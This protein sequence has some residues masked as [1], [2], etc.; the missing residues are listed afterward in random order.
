MKQRR[1]RNNRDKAFWGAVIP[2]AI[3]LAGSI[4]GTYSSHEA[5]KQAMAEQKREAIRQ[6]TLA[7][8]NADA[9]TLN[10]YYSTLHQN[11]YDTELEYKFGGSRRIGRVA[12]I[13]DGGYSIPLGRGLSLLQG[14]SHRTRNASGHTGIGIRTGNKR[15]EG[16]GGEIVQQVPGALRVFSDKLPVAGNNT[17]A[18]L[19]LSGENPDV[20][21]NAQET[22]KNYFGL[23]N[24][25]STNNSRKY[26]ARRRRLRNGGSSLPV[27]RNAS[28]R[29]KALNGA[30]Y[31]TPDYIGLGTNILGSVLSGVYANRKYRDL[32][33]DINYT[34]PSYVSESP[35]AFDTR[36][37][38]GAE[39]AEVERARR[40]AINTINN[41]T[42]S[43]NVSVERMQDANTNGVVEMNKLWD[44]KFNKENENR[45][46]VLKNEQ[47]VRAR[48]AAAQN[49]YN[50]K[51]AEIRNSQSKDRNALAQDRINS[52]V[53]TIQGIGDSVG[54]FLQQGIDRY[55]TD[56]ARKMVVA[57][58]E[59]STLHK[60]VTSGVRFNNDV[61]RFGLAEAMKM[62]D[63]PGKTNLINLY[64]SLLGIKGSGVSGIAGTTNQ[65]RRPRFNLSMKGPHYF[66]KIISPFI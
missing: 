57:A 37:R 56:Q 2:A 24:D 18:D 6:Q 19:V 17:P 21:F 43:S 8:M 28:G 15:F 53:A 9:N 51:V 66:R 3:S 62:E 44:E 63:G 47:E 42:A 32:E 26:I 40:M 58:A 12:R 50:A 64:N 25:G 54:N 7:N 27:E 14:G 5:Q 52:N 61:Y 11:P 10:N 38:N 39:R 30:I 48:N 60:M 23:N 65:G 4:F 29:P 49:E 59:P 41:N 55:D 31:T 16:E 46:T 34:I 33:R 20:V 22:M 35:V 36:Y 45:M 1:L 13:T